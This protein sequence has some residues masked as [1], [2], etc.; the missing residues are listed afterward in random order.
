MMGLAA[1]I[2]AGFGAT[3]VDPRLTSRGARLSGEG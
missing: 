1:E 3:K 2:A